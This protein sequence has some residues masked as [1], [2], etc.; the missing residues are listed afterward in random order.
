MGVSSDNSNVNDILMI[1]AGGDEFGRR[2]TAFSQ[3]RQASEDAYAEL[4]I[5]RDARAEYDAAAALKASAEAAISEARETSERILNDARESAQ[6]IAREASESRDSIVAV[7]N[8][9]REQAEAMRTSADQAQS[10]ALSII[11]QAKDEAAGILQ[12]LDA[13]AQALQDAEE[14]AQDA[15]D[16]GNAEKA[17]F[18]GLVASLRSV[19]NGA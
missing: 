7:A 8:A 13:R 18:E 16:A 2:M 12:G 11:Q 4:Q 5:G 17:K 14:K 10:S 15:I 9:L 3:A 1:A 6:R 19:M